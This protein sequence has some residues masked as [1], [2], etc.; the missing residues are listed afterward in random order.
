ADLQEILH[1]LP[2]LQ[3]PYARK[4]PA[5]RALLR[6]RDFQC[7]EHERD[8]LLLPGLPALHEAPS[9]W[10][11]LLRQN[12]DN[13]FILFSGTGSGAA[14]P[15]PALLIASCGQ[16]RARGFFCARKQGRA[17]LLEFSGSSNPPGF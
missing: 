13:F 9:P 3:A 10:R 17:T 1:H 16:G 12:V 7:P 8:R 6:L 14:L 11:L 15:D 4:T 2:E 5:D